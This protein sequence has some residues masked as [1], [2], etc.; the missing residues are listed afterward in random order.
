MISYATNELIAS[1]ELSK[2]FGA[3]LSQIRDHSV[4]KLAVLRNNKVEAVLVSKDEYEKMAEALKRIEGE[5][6]IRSIQQGLDDLQQG[7]TQP[8]DA[9]WDALNDCV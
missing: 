8:I 6:V 7:R 4:D 9:L 1:S 2:K 3:Y 5:A